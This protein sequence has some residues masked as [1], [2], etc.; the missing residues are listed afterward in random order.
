VD[1]V[2]TTPFETH[3]EDVRTVVIA[4]LFSTLMLAIS[5]IKKSR[6][7]ILYSRGV[8]PDQIG[9]ILTNVWTALLAVLIQLLLP[10]LEGRDSIV[11]YSFVA[12]LHI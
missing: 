6:V 12:L 1:R 4:L 8:H 7:V 2:I 9:V 5:H 11:I 3:V 10:P